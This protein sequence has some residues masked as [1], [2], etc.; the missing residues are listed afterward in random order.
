MTGTLHNHCTLCDGKSA[1]REMIEAAIA[2][3]YTDFGMSCHCPDERFSL[4]LRDERGYIDEMRA[5]APAYAGRIRVYCGIEQD[6]MGRMDFRGQYD[7]RIGS[8]H[9]LLRADGCGQF[10]I[11]NTPE[12]FAAGLESY[13]G[14]SVALVRDYFAAVARNVEQERPDI[15]GHFDLLLKLNGG[16]RFF[17]E[18]SPEYRAAALAALERCVEAGGV[19]EVNTGGVFRGYRDFPYLQDFLLRRLCECDARV[20]VST[21]C[22]DARDIAFGVSDALERIARAGFTRVAVWRDGGFVDQSLDE[23]G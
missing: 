14:D 10:C 9:S 20:T 6:P 11:D 5:L 21:D 4:S 18:S 7:Y 13:G 17:D 3:G 16:S 22:H 8:V 12:D 2:A 1:P 19:F 15:I 23:L